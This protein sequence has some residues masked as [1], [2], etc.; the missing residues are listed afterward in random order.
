MTDRVEAMK[1]LVEQIREVVNQRP[2]KRGWR[3]RILLL[4]ATIDSRLGLIAA[5]LSEAPAPQVTR[6]EWIDELGRRLTRCNCQVELSY[7]DQGRTLKLFV[8]P[9]PPKEPR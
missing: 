5:G 9:A 4:L 6:L 1:A 7:Q 2:Q 3:V 8:S